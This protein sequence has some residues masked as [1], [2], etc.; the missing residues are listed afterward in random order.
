VV[1]PPR[2]E[3]LRRAWG[4]CRGIVHQR[5]DVDAKV[6]R[7]ELEAVEVRLIL[8]ITGIRRM[9]RAIRVTAFTSTIPMA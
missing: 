5:V 4:R 2:A 9:T 6:G 3:A 7:L 8:A 1:R